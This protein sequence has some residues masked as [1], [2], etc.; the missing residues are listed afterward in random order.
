MRGESCEEVKRDHGAL[1]NYR[2]NWIFKTNSRCKWV[3]A[4]SSQ[5]SDRTWGRIRQRSAYFRASSRCTD[6]EK[7]ALASLGSSSLIC[8]LLIHQ[9][10]KTPI[11]WSINGQHESKFQQNKQNFLC[12]PLSSHSKLSRAR[13]ALRSEAFSDGFFAAIQINFPFIKNAFEESSFEWARGGRERKRTAESSYI[14]KLEEKSDEKYQLPLS[15]A[16]R[17]SMQTPF[18]DWTFYDRMQSLECNKF[19]KKLLET[20]VRSSGGPAAPHYLWI[21]EEAN[22]P[23]GSSVGRDAVQHE[24]NSPSSRLFQFPLL[25]HINCSS[26]A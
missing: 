15:S 1:A 4:G 21:F 16:S 3:L 17:K 24:R 12:F 19:V 23:K 26:D 9:T 5:P 20:R 11:C 8:R 18:G 2:R 6:S 22:R 25:R 7:S 13:S 10:D 14:I